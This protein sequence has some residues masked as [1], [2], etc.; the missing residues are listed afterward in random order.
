[1]TLLYRH[2]LEAEDRILEEIVTVPDEFLE[3]HPIDIHRGVGEL[4]FFCPVEG[5]GKIDREIDL[6]DWIQMLEDQKYGDHYSGG[7]SFDEWIKTLK[8]P[9]ST[10]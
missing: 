10:S 6:E 9:A 8:D 5:D 2:H 4:P 7:P 1:M 3:D